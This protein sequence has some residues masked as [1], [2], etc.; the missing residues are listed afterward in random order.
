MSPKTRCVVSKFYRSLACHLQSHCNYA[1]QSISWNLYRI[2]F[3]TVLC[4]ISMEK[5]I[6]INSWDI[7]TREEKCFCSQMSNTLKQ[8]CCQMLDSNYTSLN[9]PYKAFLF[10]SLN[11]LEISVIQHKDNPY[12]L[13]LSKIHSCSHTCQSVCQGLC[14]HVPTEFCDFIYNEVFH[15]QSNLQYVLH[16]VQPSHHYECPE[17]KWIIFLNPI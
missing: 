11:V 14:C 9:L 15:S 1:I 13:E 17:I 2:I 5:K 3:G 6:L 4:F 8:A 12:L 10:K 7:D 16:F